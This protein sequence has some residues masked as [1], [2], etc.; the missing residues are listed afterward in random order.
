MGET[1]GKTLAWVIGSIVLYI[2]LMLIE[3]SMA[4]YD[5]SIITRAIAIIGSIGL[6]IIIF[7]Q[8]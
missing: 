3:G 4:F 2:V 1:G 6:G 8:D 5:W 7:N